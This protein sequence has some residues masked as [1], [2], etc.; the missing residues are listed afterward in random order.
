MIIG[1]TYYNAMLLTR[2]RLTLNG[3]IIIYIYIYRERER[4]RERERGER[5]YKICK[6]KF[7]KKKLK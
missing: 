3:G 5:F 7:T 4:E 2:S 6:L 1:N